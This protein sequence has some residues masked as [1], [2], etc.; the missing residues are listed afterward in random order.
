MGRRKGNE[1]ERRRRGVKR[2]QG[3]ERKG[4]VRKKEEKRREKERGKG[5]MVYPTFGTK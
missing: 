3:G 4:K 1:G 2:M 5:E